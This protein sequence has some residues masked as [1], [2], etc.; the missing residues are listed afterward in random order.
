MADF[1]GGWTCCVEQGQYGHYA[2]KPTI[3]YVHGI[4][5]ADLPSLAWGYSEP[6][7]DP[8]VVARMGLQ[9]AKLRPGSCRSHG[10]TAS[11]AP[12]GSRRPRRRHGQF[13][14]DRYACA[15]PRSPHLSGARRAAGLSF[16]GR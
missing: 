5:A 13:A 8:A 1:E 2:R 10:A 11:Q 16:G 4:E 9:R 3:L 12:R 15:I 7:F 6:S 14:A